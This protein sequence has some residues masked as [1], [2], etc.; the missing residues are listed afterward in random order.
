MKRFNAGHARTLFYA[1][2]ILYMGIVPYTVPNT[3]FYKPA[4]N[5]SH[6]H[7][8]RLQALSLIARCKLFP[9]ESP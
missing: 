9:T 2:L 3:V 5:A 7:Y 8:D 6:T 4:Y 1:T